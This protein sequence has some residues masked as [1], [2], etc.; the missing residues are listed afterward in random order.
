MGFQRTTE[1]SEGVDGGELWREYRD[2]FPITR[3]LIYLNHAAVAPLARRT[4]DAMKRLADDVCDYGSLHY[5]EWLDAYQGVRN[6]T[7][8]LINADPAEIAV[9]KNTS[10]G[11]ATIAAGFVW[12]PGDVVVAFEEE[13]PANLFPWKRLEEKGVE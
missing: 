9:M 1:V 11:I 10:E 4:A 6:A 5:D 8:R 2:E 7:A 13:F 3:N 12:K